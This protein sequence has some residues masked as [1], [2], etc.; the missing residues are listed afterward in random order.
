M[1]P[2]NHQLTTRKETTMGTQRLDTVVIG[3]G[4]AGL[5]TGYHLTRHHTD[6]VILDAGQRVGAAWRDRWDS[7]RL[8]TPARFNH[9]PGMPFPAPGGYFPTKDEMADYLEAYAARFDLPV[10]LGVR[11][12]ELGRDGNGYLITAGHRSLEARH[13]V[14]ATGAAT[15]PR[16]PAFAEQLDPAIVQLHS[17]DYR[18][19]GQLRDGAVLVVGAGNSGA[20]IAL[21]LARTHRIWLAGRD[22]GRIPITLGGPVFEAMNR[23]LT[24]DTRLGRRFA[25]QGAG[26]GT[27]LVRVRPQDLTDAGVQRTPRVS[28]V[29]GGRPVLDDGRVLEVDNVV[30]CTGF[31]RDHRWIRLP[32]F[33][34]GGDPVHHR[35]VVDAAPGLYFVGLPLQY[36]LA[37]SL[38]GGVGAD[39]QHLVEQITARQVAARAAA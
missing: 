29:R 10:E 32:V 24:V 38:V 14:V 1:A 6:F 34:P 30:W 37:S 36:S 21:E 17:V 26:R 13:V 23:L 8:F 3:G 7:L 39:A 33:G 35:G 12:D 25:A 5:A 22:T 11:V 31:A 2:R 15:T 19:P 28:G 4:Q 9:L 18:N 27:P 20:E 16:V